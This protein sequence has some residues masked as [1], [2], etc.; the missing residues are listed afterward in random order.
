VALDLLGQ[1]ADRVVLIPLAW[2]KLAE[3]HGP[4]ARLD[5]VG[6]L[7]SGAGLL[8]LVWGLVEAASVGWGDP[9]VLPALGAGLAGL[10]GFV[11]WERR[12]AAPMLPL[13]FFRARE[14]SAASA[15]SLIAYFGMLGALFLIGQ[16]LQT[17]L[18]ASPLRAGLGLLAMTGAM[19]ATAPVAGA[20]CDRLGPRQLMTMALSVEVLGLAWLA[21]AAAPGVT[22]ARLAPGL[23]LCGIGAG[24]LFTP[25]QATLLGAVRPAQQGQ[26]AGA[27]NGLRELGGVLGVSVLG[28]IFAANGSAASPDAFLAGFRPALIVAALA[29]G[30]AAV[31]A[32]RL[33]GRR[34]VP[35][36]LTR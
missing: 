4:Y 19:A 33:P 13:T 22:Y 28:T 5:R 7:L 32:F 26:A 21:V 36:L 6:I 14:F 12:A 18:G 17:G 31:V 10:V 29:V 20:L 11:A 9:R 24:T 25:V 2:R 27:A 3:S 23:V 34:M 8:A 1:R 16:L 15:V 35:A 30:I